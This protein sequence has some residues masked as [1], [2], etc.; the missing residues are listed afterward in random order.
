[1]DRN[2]DLLEDKDPLES[3]RDKDPLN[4]ELEQCSKK[5]AM[6]EK[7]LD[8]QQRQRMALIWEKREREANE[9][10]KRKKE[11]QESIRQ[12][13]ERKEKVVVWRNVK[14][15][16]PAEFYDTQETDSWL[17]DCETGTRSHEGALFIA[18]LKTEF[19]EDEEKEAEP[20]ADE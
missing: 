3:P 5:I 17:Q 14:I 20:K 7:E 12:R 1:M 18:Y 16:A 11:V 15:E 4:D 2:E 9:I 19:I 10:E 6:L 13:F 8:E